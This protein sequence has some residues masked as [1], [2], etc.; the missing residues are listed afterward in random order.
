MRIQ[1]RVSENGK[2]FEGEALLKEV[3][4][5]GNTPPTKI[6]RRR[7]LAPT[8]PTGAVDGLYETQFFACERTL[9]QV[10][11]KLG[12]DGFNFNAPSIFMALKSRDYIQRRGSRGSYRFVQKFPPKSP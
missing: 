2:L 8:K 7:E 4:S 12:E 6:G 10:M 5:K 1:I 11:G 9:G 3:P